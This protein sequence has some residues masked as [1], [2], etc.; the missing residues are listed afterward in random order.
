M[1]GGWIRISHRIWIIWKEMLEQLVSVTDGGSAGHEAE[2][3]DAGSTLSLS[4]LNKL[5]VRSLS[6]SRLDW[7]KATT[8]KIARLP[9]T[10]TCNCGGRDNGKLSLD[11]PLIGQFKAPNQSDW[12]REL[13]EHARRIMSLV[14]KTVPIQFIFLTQQAFFMWS[15]TCDN[16]NKMDTRLWWY[17][18]LL[19]NM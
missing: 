8:N 5:R 4:P 14:G 3:W 10:A 19:C 17:N 9:Q 12:S 7:T 18:C 11:C 2:G 6:P 15:V 13:L 16:C 1:A